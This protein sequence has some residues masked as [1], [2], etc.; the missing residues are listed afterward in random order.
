[1]G[2]WLT[3]CLCP[4]FRQQAILAGDSKDPTLKEDKNERTKMV[5]RGNRGAVGRCHDD[6]ARRDFMYRQR[7]Q[8]ALA[9]SFTCPLAERHSVWARHAQRADLC[10]HRLLWRQ[11]DIY[12]L[13]L[14]TSSSPAIPYGSCLSAGGRYNFGSS[15]L[16]GNY[17]TPVWSPDGTR[18][19]YTFRP[20]GSDATYIEVMDITCDHRQ[21][22]T[23]SGSEHSSGV[24]NT[25]PDWWPEP[26][27]AS[28][29]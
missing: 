21:R 2:S 12:R 26:G 23:R 11:P 20:L 16:D 13:G 25:D 29:D 22:L 4:F 5:Y 3:C 24:R 6:C 27:A 14:L 10:P 1:M 28:D 7:R 8:S 17:T 19:A 18:L 15:S 9:G